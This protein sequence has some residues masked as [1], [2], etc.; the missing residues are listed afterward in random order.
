MVFPFNSSGDTNPE[1][2]GPNPELIEKDVMKLTEN[3]SK[4]VNNELRIVDNYIKNTKAFI[5]ERKSNA[6]LNY[7]SN[8]KFHEPKNNLYQIFD[9]TLPDLNLPFSSL[10]QRFDFRQLLKRVRR[11]YLN[12]LRQVDPTLYRK[13]AVKFFI[14]EVDS[15]MT[16]NGKFRITFAKKH[17]KGLSVM[18]KRLIAGFILFL[19][20]KL[21]IF[22]YRRVIPFLEVAFQVLVKKL[23]NKK[24]KLNKQSIR[25]KD[26]YEKIGGKK[27]FWDKPFSWVSKITKMSRG[28]SLATVQEINSYS[29]S[30][31]D[32]PQALQIVS[33]IPVF[34]KFEKHKV[35]LER[36][37]VA[38]LEPH[39]QRR[40]SRF[41][42]KF[43]R[44]SPLQ[45]PSINYKSI[46]IFFG[47]LMFLVGANN[48][49]ILSPQNQ[50][51]PNIERVVPGQRFI[52]SD[53]LQVAPSIEEPRVN[54]EKMIMLIP[55]KTN[56][57]LKKTESISSR[58]KS[59]TRTRKK[60]KVAHLSDLPPLVDQ[61]SDLDIGMKSSSTSI[62]IKIKTR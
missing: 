28:G 4:Q 57:P 46:V 43:K 13:E 17:R 11:E 62:D 29:F 8:G 20:Y 58:M 51:L 34:S 19:L 2:L 23:W 60:A 45:A 52:T 40:F 26:E 59:V 61:Y 24:S 36:F 9:S 3:L 42:F 47:V 50:N 27:K 41:K 49:T 53:L 15:I 16:S 10:I 38:H 48:G 35:K 56:E 5:A 18:V 22:I 37:K 54:E 44:W 1:N 32:R 25:Q 39:I 14:K 31:L 12:Y 21:V 6:G 55:T 33:S 30:E 7:P